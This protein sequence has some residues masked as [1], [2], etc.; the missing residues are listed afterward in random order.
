MTAIGF[1]GSSLS[2]WTGVFRKERLYIMEIEPVIAAFTD[3]VRLK[4]PCL[5]P[6]SYRVGMNVQ[7]V[8]Y[9]VYRE[10]LPGCRAVFRHIF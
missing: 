6:E 8:G 10:H 1:P 7:Q 5:A 9:L 3:A 4:R 2:L